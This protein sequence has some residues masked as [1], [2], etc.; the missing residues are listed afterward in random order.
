MLSF[1]CAAVVGL[2]SRYPVGILVDDS[3][4][5]RIRVGYDGSLTIAGR[6]DYK[7]RGNDE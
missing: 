1:G 6:A 2:S 3:S 7:G 5:A 4:F